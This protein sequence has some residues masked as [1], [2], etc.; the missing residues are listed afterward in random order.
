MLSV[1]LYH[2]YGEKT[3]V[4]A[5]LGS[6]Q[7]PLFFFLSG[8][9]IKEVATW[10][11]LLRK[12]IQFLSPFFIIGMIYSYAINYTPIDFVFAEMKFGYWYLWVLAEFYVLYYLMERFASKMYLFII[13]SIV[14]W[15]M[16]KGGLQFLSDS[17]IGFLSLNQASVYW[18]F[19]IAAVLFRK[20]NLLTKMDAKE[21]LSG[22]LL[23]FYSVTFVL[24]SVKGI[25]LHIY[26]LTSLT[27]VLSIIYVYKKRFCATDNKIAKMLR[28]IG[29]NSL[30]VYT[31][32]Y[33]WKIGWNKATCGILLPDSSYW[34][35][36][37]LICLA[38][39]I[40]LCYL[41]IFLGKIIRA[42][43]LSDVIYGKAILS[44]IQ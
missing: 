19:F 35:I 18:P 1:V 39:S 16:I 38:V 22:G 28:T 44:K 7:L 42:T 10:K 32:H 17:S 43:S 3:V 9:V 12:S 34:L 24:Q 8:Y 41:S 40:L 27:A 30:D 37:I 13:Q 26:M 4:G 33:L 14:I 23:L 6:Y 11:K 29:K 15:L 2:M 36:N 5:F 31:L 21:W 25:V 20:Y